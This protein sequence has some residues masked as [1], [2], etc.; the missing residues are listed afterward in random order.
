MIWNVR[1]RPRTLCRGLVTQ[2]VHAKLVVRCHQ[3]LDTI[4]VRAGEC[5]GSRLGIAVL[6][7]DPPPHANHHLLHK[8]LLLDLEIFRRFLAHHR[9]TVLLLQSK[10][11]FPSSNDICTW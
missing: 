4:T 8:V 11:G 1:L 9:V 7:S 10:P 6:S 3:E 5:E 2:C